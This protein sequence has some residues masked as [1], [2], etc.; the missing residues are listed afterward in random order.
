MGAYASAIIHL[1]H[2]FG[3][4]VPSLGLPSFRELICHGTTPIP[5]TWFVFVLAFL[6][7]PFWLSHYSSWVD[8]HKPTRYMPQH[9]DQGLKV[10]LRFCRRSHTSSTSCMAL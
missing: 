8:A 9:S 1:Y 5:D 2:S 4:C 7:L 6:Y 3:V 10:T